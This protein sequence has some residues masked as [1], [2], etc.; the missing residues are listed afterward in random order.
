MTIYIP[1]GYF[2][3]FEGGEGCGKSTQIGLLEKRLSKEGFDV[4]PV[5]DTRG[6]H[7]GENKIRPLAVN[8][9]NERLSPR[10]KF[11]LFSISR[12]N[13]VRERIAP[14]LKKGRIVLGHRFGDASKIYQG[15]VGGV[16]LGFIEI[17]NRE[18]CQGVRPNL[19]IVLDVDPYVG[20]KRTKHDDNLS[21][22]PHFIAERGIEYHR[23]I[24]DAYRALA[25]LHKDRMVLIPYRDGDI[26]WM[27]KKIY[28]ISKARIDEKLVGSGRLVESKD[29]EASKE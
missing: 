27:H 5:D 10:Q 15:I 23:K 12:E 3:S 8:T 25:G 21:G 28:E 16:D 1:G 13:N 7:L 6:T 20:L 18:V 11:L 24:N 26:G 17:V 9:P 14:S 4:V 2:I 19:T 22:K 29:L